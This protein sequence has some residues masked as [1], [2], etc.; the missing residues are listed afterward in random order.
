MRNARSLRFATEPCLV[1]AVVVG[2]KLVFLSGKWEFLYYHASTASYSKSNLFL[3]LWKRDCVLDLDSYLSEE[4][5]YSFFPAT[6]DTVLATK[7]EET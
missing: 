2:N 5:T 3:S 6:L 4:Q 7:H 1:G